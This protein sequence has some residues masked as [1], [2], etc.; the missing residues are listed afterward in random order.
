MRKMNKRSDYWKEWHKNPRLGISKG[1]PQFQPAN[2]QLIVETTQ[3][4]RLSRNRP[5]SI[6]E[7]G[8][9]SGYLCKNLIGKYQSNIANYT[10]IEDKRILETTRKNLEKCVQVEYCTIDNVEE[11]QPD[12]NY[13]LL[14]SCGCLEET[15]DEYR[16]FVYNNFFPVINEVFIIMMHGSSEQSETLLQKTLKENFEKVSDVVKVSHM[17][18]WPIYLHHASKF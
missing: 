17:A 8:P 11:S 14:V 10:L 9:G 1:A 18:N 5:V 6:I 16:D 4:D 15:T 7:F 2:A 3:I 13:D 12:K